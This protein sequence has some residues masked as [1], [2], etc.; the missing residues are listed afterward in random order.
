MVAQRLSLVVAA[1]EATV[2][3]FRYDQV[4]KIGE[5]ARE[6]GRQYI[7]TV[8]G[9]L[10]EPLFEG[11]G[12]PKWG[13]AD[14]PVAARRGGKVVEVAQGHT[15][16]PRHVVEHAVEGAAAFGRRRRRYR[17]VERVATDIITDPASHQGLVGV[18]QLCSRS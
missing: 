5:C 12:N 7:V 17:A 3:E 18:S 2:L 14:D 16:P 15:L 6:I 8:G 11:V 10:D 9:A 13:A 4:D 1:E